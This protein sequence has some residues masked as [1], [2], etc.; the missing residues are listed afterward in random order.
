MVHTAAPQRFIG[1]QSPTVD[2]EEDV[3]LTLRL[4]MY[5]CMCIYIYIYI[6]ETQIKCHSVSSFKLLC[7]HFF[8]QPLVWL[9]LCQ[10]KKCPFHPITFDGGK[11]PVTISTYWHILLQQAIKWTVSEA[12]TWK[13]TPL[14]LS[15]KPSLKPNMFYPHSSHS[16]HD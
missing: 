4:L 2:Y 7:C 13:S 3:P 10:L 12:V 9:T 16:S 1:I 15:S 14:C 6:N 11:V 8:S 5:V